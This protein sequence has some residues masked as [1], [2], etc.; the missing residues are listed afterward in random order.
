LEASPEGVLLASGGAA[1]TSIG[2]S[3]VMLMVGALI[4]AALH[5]KHLRGKFAQKA[6][7]ESLPVSSPT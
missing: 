7:L 6:G 2:T 3:G 1:A 5:A 4:K